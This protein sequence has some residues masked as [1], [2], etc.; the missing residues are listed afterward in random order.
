MC[1]RLTGEHDQH[2]GILISIMMIVL[3]YNISGYLGP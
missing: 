1:I 3:I 2:K